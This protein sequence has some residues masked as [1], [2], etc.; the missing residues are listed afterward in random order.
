MAQELTQ[1]AIRLLVG[2]GLLSAVLL[3]L[4]GLFAVLYGGDGGSSGNTYVKLFGSEIDAGLVGAIAL[5]IA[6]VL[7]VISLPL[8][9]RR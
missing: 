9:R 8:I 6:A 5:L 3:A 2:L 1:R 4:Y 7:L